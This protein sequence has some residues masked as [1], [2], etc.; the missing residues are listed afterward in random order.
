MPDFQHLKKA[1]IA[2][3]TLE[4]R[5]NIANFIN[6]LKNIFTERFKL[7]FSELKTQNISFNPLKGNIV[8]PA[9]STIGI[10]ARTETDVI[11]IR[12]D[13]LLFSRIKEYDTFNDINKYVQAA[14]ESNIIKDVSRIG[15]RYINIFSINKNYFPEDFYN[16]SIY[17][18]DSSEKC[19]IFKRE[20][21]KINDFDVILINNI[22]ESSDNILNITLDVDVSVSKPID[23]K[24]I[25]DIVLRT[26]ELKNKIFFSYINQYKEVFN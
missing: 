7:E 26:R 10:E 15:C 24:Q 3:A 4:I 2:E 12:Q 8:I 20:V 23:I 19:Q 17:K 14:I 11:Q 1:P 18:E 25:N 13:G 9:P 22:A 5:G 21:S 16:L 6:D